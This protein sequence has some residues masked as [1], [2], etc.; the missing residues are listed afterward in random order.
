MNFETECMFDIMNNRG[1]IIRD[2][3]F[4]DLDKSIP[5][6][7]GPRS[8]RYGGT[9]SSESEYMEKSRCECGKY[10]GAAFEGETCPDCGTKIEYRDVDML[11]TGWL[12]FF[13]YKIISPL[14]FHKLQSALSKKVLE[15]I[16]SNENIITANGTIRSHNDTFEVKKSSLIYHNIGLHAF[17]ENF[18]EIMTYYKNKRKQK[19]DLI[20]E[21]IENKDLVWTDK[22]P[23]YSTVLRPQ[24]ISQESYF[25]SPIDREIYPLTNISLKL[26]KASPIE[27][28]LYL[29]QAQ[30][31][32]NQLWAL[33]FSLIDKKNGKIRASILGGEFNYSGRNVIVLDPTL[34]IDEVDVPYKSFIIQ[35]RG[36][37][38]RRIVK[39][40]GWTVTK[41]SNYVSSKFEFDPYI[42]KIMCDIIEEETPKII[43]NRNPTITFGSILMMRIRKIK[44]DSNDCTLSIP[45]AILPGLNAD[46]TLM[47]RS[48]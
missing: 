3:P 6:M 9:W 33:N 22:L 43:L 7:D 28:P 42:Y 1:F 37:I 21:L 10:I 46:L 47:S 39:D 4:S 40:K 14:W 11:Y 17:Y 12:N 36:F 16:I 23:V 41:A 25:F 31:R 18:Y 20:D 19:A 2:V 8:P 5:N 27:V 34:K 29:Y 13:P 35:Y 30:M 48:A 32:A 44:P 26:K 45:S 15:N 38:I 24:S